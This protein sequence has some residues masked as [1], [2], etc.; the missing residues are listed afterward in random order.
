MACPRPHDQALGEP[1]SVRGPPPTSSS[2]LPPEALLALSPF[3]QLVAFSEKASLPRMT[4][5]VAKRI[6]VDPRVIANMSFPTV[7]GLGTQKSI[8]PFLWELEE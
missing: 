1:G 6:Q 8:P 3:L 4:S 5:T 2:P 7:V